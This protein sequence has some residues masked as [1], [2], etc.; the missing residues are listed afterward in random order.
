[1]AAK[2]TSNAATANPFP[3]NP[4]SPQSTINTVAREIKEAGG[5]A[6][7]IQVDVRAAESIQHLIDQTVKVTNQPIFSYHIF[8]PPLSRQ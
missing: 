2:T 6:T 4:N 7:A 8:N 3:P 5:E 1:V